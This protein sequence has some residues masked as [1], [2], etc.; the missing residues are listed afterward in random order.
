[1]GTLLFSSPVSFY[2]M[3]T[4]DPTDTHTRDPTDLSICPMDTGSPHT[5][6]LLFMSHGHC[7][8][9][10]TSMGPCSAVYSN[11]T[12]TGDPTGHPWDS[13][14]YS[15]VYPAYGRQR[16]HRTSMGHCSMVG[17]PYVPWTLGIS[18]DIHGTQQYGWCPP[19]PYVP[20]TLGIPW[21]TAV[22]LVSQCPP[23]PYVPQTLG[24][25]WDTAVWLVS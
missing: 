17:V 23:R 12:D 2:P 25:P 13:T 21:D 16:S 3:D 22:W 9:N 5:H 11:L 15:S 7:K 10:W 1:M 6:T 24:I 14:Q 8:V 18:W 20:Q 19:R 4:G